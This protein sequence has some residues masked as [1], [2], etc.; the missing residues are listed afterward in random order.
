M[1]L[2]LVTIL[3][4]I[5][6]SSRIIEESFKI[7][8]T[9]SII[10]LAFLVSY[11]F[12]N[13]FIINHQEFDE[14]LYLMLPVI[15]LPD[16]LNLSIT[17]L[18]KHAKEIFYLAFIAV[19]IS[20]IIASTITPYLLP[21]YQWNIGILIALFS[22]LMATDAITVA[23]IMHKFKLP[24]QLKV[25]A[26]SESLF[27]DVTA[28]V[29]FYFIAIP[30][31]NGG[32]VTLLSINITLFSVLILSV[33]IGVVVASIGYFS[34]KILKNTFDQFLIIYLVVIVSFLLAEHFHIA[35]I[36]SIVSS[37]LTFKILVQKEL[38]NE[39]SNKNMDN[40]IYIQRNVLELIKKVPAITKKEFREYKKEAMFIGIFANAIVFVIIANILNLDDMIFYYKEIMIIFIITTIIRYGSI[41]TLIKVF[42]LPS[43]WIQALT[44]AG[45]KG[46]LAIIMSHSL[47][48]TFIYKEMFI[49]IVIGN[50]ILSTFIYTILLMIHIAKYT[51]AYKQ[52]IITF[53]ETKMTQDDYNRCLIDVIEKD[54]I[55][56]AYNKS[57][58]EDILLH[59]MAR[60]QRYKIDL[61]L[62][63]IEIPYDTKD[64]ILKMIGINVLE[65]IRVNDYFGK[66]SEVRY[67]IITS[68]TSLSGA[69]VLAEKLL[70]D[71]EEKNPIKL[72]CGVTEISDSDTMDSVFDKI[73][74]ALSRAILKDGQQIEV[75]V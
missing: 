1:M 61:S 35:G 30:L 64:D 31:L 13:L 20:I 12:P 65:R 67:I 72:F 52:D 70:L 63:C 59:E 58:I 29:I 36:L 5:I 16:I 47:P 68:N 57:F 60:S 15:L 45:S 75:E 56:N 66:I 74:D 25:Y 26:E 14:I 19:I 32:D 21:Q 39:N 51:Q 44:L 54:T 2:I 34:I 53:D 6:I 22:M 71:I 42:N 43:R 50:V 40:Q 55:T 17:E 4:I 62:L 18:K 11:L 69:I 7:P 8:S 41:L 27:N 49:S 73:D 9:L 10:V 28:L 48:N 23:S 38:F 24:E 3:L 37:V 46:A 33:V